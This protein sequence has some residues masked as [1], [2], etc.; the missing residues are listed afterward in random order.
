MKVVRPLFQSFGSTIILGLPRFPRTT[1]WATISPQP[2]PSKGYLSLLPGG[3]PIFALGFGMRGGFLICSDSDTLGRFLD[4]SGRPGFRPGLCLRSNLLASSSSR[5][6]SLAVSEARVSLFGEM[7]VP[8]HVSCI[9]VMTVRATGLNNRFVESGSFIHLPLES[10]GRSSY[11]K[12]PFSRAWSRFSGGSTVYLG[13]TPTPSNPL[14]AA[15][16]FHINCVII[17]ALLICKKAMGRLLVCICFRRPSEARSGLTSIPNTSLLRQSAG[18]LVKE[19]S[20]SRISTGEH[21]FALALH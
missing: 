10:L 9:S 7:G 1:D 2:P 8:S 17:P 21:V 19:P 13:V 5:D 16:R 18:T 20:S 3:R 12:A 15:A 6:V 4:P 11:L 14:S